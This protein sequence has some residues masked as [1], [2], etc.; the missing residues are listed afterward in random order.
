LPRNQAS[1]LQPFA[2]E[3]AGAV[4]G[5]YKLREK[6][7]EGGCGVVYVA[8]QEQ[9][10]RRQVALKVIKLGMDT[11]SVV[12]RFEAERQALA[13]MDHPNIA[14]VLDAGATETGRPYFVMELVRG[15]KITD[16]CD[17]NQLSTRERLELFIKVCQAVQHAHQKGII[18]R[19]LKPSNILVTM[20]YPDR[21]GVPKVIDFGIAKAIEGRLTDLTVYTELYQFIGTPAYMSPEQALMSSDPLGDIDTRSDIYSLGALLYE[22]LTGETPFDTKELLTAGPDE[23]R[24][25]IREKEPVRPSTRLR[26]T[27]ESEA[28]GALATRHSPL[29]SDLDWI[30][31]KCLEKDRARRYETANALGT[32][33]QRH[34][35]HE[36][37]I[38]RPPSRI[39][40]F[41]KTVRRHK[42]AF[43]AT[44]AVIAAL[45]A[46]AI[47]STWQAVVATHAKQAQTAFANAAKT[48]KARAEKNAA[49]SRE[50]L[51]QLNLA[52]GTRLMKEGNFPDALLWFASALNLDQGDP[53]RERYH[54]LRCASVLQHCAQPLHILVHEGVVEYAEFSADGS[55]II[56]V[57]DAGTAR[58]WDATTGNPITPPMSH[59]GRL[60]QAALSPDG[61]RA[62]TAGVSSA[63]PRAVVWNADTGE[64]IFSLRH[65][66][67]VCHAEFSPDGRHVL[68]AGLDKKAQVWDAATGKP[69]LPPFRHNGAVRQAHFNSDG[70]RIVTAS[71][72]KTARVWDAMTGQPVTPPL[73]HEEAVFSAVFSPD[74]HYIVT[75][76]G[77][78][79]AQL[80]DASTGHRIGP[81]LQGSNAVWSASF[82]PDGKRILTGTSDG[83]RVWD[84]GTGVSMALAYKHPVGPR[85]LELFPVFSPDGRLILAPFDDDR[86]GVFDAVTL[87]AITPPL[88]HNFQEHGSFSP[89]SR[90]LVTCSVDRA[91]V[92]ELGT[93]S[94]RPRPSRPI[95]VVNRVSISPDR[96]RIALAVGDAAAQIFDA[97]TGSP[98]SPPLGHEG[99][100]IY[101]RFNPDG[102]YLVT[103]GKDYA[104][105]VWDVLNGQP[106]GPPLHHSD[107]PDAYGYIIDVAF[108]PDSRK[109]AT[110]DVNDLRLWDLPVGKPGSKPIR[111]GGLVE[112]IA[113][114]P[115]G[116]SLVT[117]CS[118]TAGPNGTVRVWDVETAEPR[119]APLLL[120]EGV[121]HAAF[122]PDGR[123]FVTASYDGTAQ[124]WDATTGEPI[125]APLQH[126]RPVLCAEFNS[127]STRV[128]TATESGAWVW[129]LPLDD[130]P[131]KEV[132]LYA[133]VLAGHQIDK[134]GSLT[135]LAAE[136]I[137]SGWQQVRA[138]SPNRAMLGGCNGPIPGE[139]DPTDPEAKKFFENLSFTCR[140]QNDTNLKPFCV[141]LSPFFNDGLTNGWAALPTGRQQFAGV[142]FDIRGIIRLAGDGTEKW[143]YNSLKSVSGIKVGRKCTLLHF[144]QG[145]NGSRM[146]FYAE[147]LVHFKNGQKWNIPVLGED[148][149]EY[150]LQ[151]ADPNR[152]KRSTIVWKGTEQGTHVRLYQTTWQNPLPDL[153]VESIDFTSA[154][155][156]NSA[157]LVALTVE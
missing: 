55:R 24:R 83:L 99:T 26:Q 40:E 126:D 134:S 141:D 145:S 123:L 15:I 119:T 58:V 97:S 101:T 70:Q 72:D 81:P 22:L 44:G 23:L 107:T 54:R 113:F 156:W 111:P 63:L 118:R 4:I 59:P 151:D 124:V 47:V 57:S 56:T 131:A 80:W 71:E 39:Y 19:D 105:R 92:W 16:Y 120:K 42:L 74:G 96:H 66:S 121:G 144:L 82:S 95:S 154:M 33:I 34:L 108:S 73:Q 77:D 89:D 29:A 17:Q 37:V 130:R 117:A 14:K 115:D 138:K 157:F 60:L 5:R 25:T 78:R 2:A 133:S 88:P 41:Q 8:D 13:M 51:V 6:L 53:I 68:T 21:V 114:S 28:R 103:T 84:I 32:D 7:G 140:S 110:A 153:E 3:A 27:A 128:F 50:R 52:N 76:S 61:H 36:P 12:A 122:S 146:E 90:R 87:E 31:M 67:F 125:T 49:E 109:V 18:H 79:T 38:A 91:W 106:I 135:Q 75:G 147:Y 98:L 150:S 48:E 129:D 10:V 104:A 94:S 1:L 35:N 65:D 69:S 11:R 139:L 100:V 116:R 86:A 43:I 148:V 155:S 143:G 45:G 137:R 152:A 46:G 9:P 102:R 20:H 127:D 85:S 149:I 93:G 136:E 112:H 132:L 62:L 142:E 64:Q 30:V